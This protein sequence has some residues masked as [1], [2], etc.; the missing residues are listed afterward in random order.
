[1]R[2]RSLRLL[3]RLP[4][5]RTIFTITILV[6][7]LTTFHLLRKD[8]NYKNYLIND[9]KNIQEQNSDI[10]STSE[11]KLDNSNIIIDSS[12]SNKDDNNN[13]LGNLHNS[14]SIVNYS[15][16]NVNSNIQSTQ[17]QENTNN[18]V[19][20]LIQDGNNENKN[21]KK[22]DVSAKPESPFYW[23]KH[24][25]DILA[26]DQTEKSIS[27]LVPDFI[28]GRPKDFELRV[29]K[30]L[31]NWNIATRADQCRILVD[32][33]YRNNKWTNLAGLDKIT[34]DY[35]IDLFG[36]A[37][38]RLRIYNYCFI[39]GGLTYDDI[40]DD[41]FDGTAITRYDFQN[42]M[43][44]FLRQI[45]EN[46]KKQEGDEEN[47]LKA[48]IIWPD[49]YTYDTSIDSFKKNDAPID[50]EPNGNIWESL[51]RHSKGR[52]IVSTMNADHLPMFFKQLKTLDRLGNKLPIQVV[53]TD[54]DLNEEF[55]TKMEE[56]M[57]STN[58][59]VEIMDVTQIMDPD[60][61]KDHISCF[62][63]KWLSVMFNTFEEYI[64]MDVDVVP[65]VDT[66]EFFEIEKYKET[67]I[68]LYKD[69][70]LP[71]LTHDDRCNDF[72]QGIEPSWQEFD[73]IG[74]VAP[75]DQAWLQQNK[76]IPL[77]DLA[78]SE[79]QV[80]QNYF[81]RNQLHHVD[82][83]LVIVDKSRK[84]TGIITSFFLDLNKRI[85]G[86]SYGDKEIFWLGQLAASEPYSI[87]PVEP[88]ITGQIHENIDPEKPD[89]IGV[90]GT[91]IAHANEDEKLTWT[92]GGLRTCK[93][94]DG[95]T[96]DFEKFPDYFQEHYGNVDQLGQF[97][98]SPLEM[99][100]F[101]IPSIHKEQTWEPR[102][103][104]KGYFFC[105]SSL[106]GSNNV[107]LDPS[108]VVKFDDTEK[109]FYKGLADA[110]NNV[111]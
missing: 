6:C 15:D 97:Y 40:F 29:S 51:F 41:Y 82:S 98:S 50:I 38:E 86:C 89:K 72:F 79:A 13:D 88:G 108:V 78:S 45:S 67:G 84:L 74:T 22:T 37:T 65:F 43:F 61:L 104:C 19:N 33:I 93:F 20:S 36:F 39:Q 48:N 32:S 64:F 55:F 71:Q 31:S 23:T 28:S 101:I 110:W 30:I 59:T 80:F 24:L 60:V 75:F 49:I 68:H 100:G 87:D 10:P 14:E 12:E 27:A 2:G 83:G 26:N 96:Y 63:F 44:P 94:D 111:Y 17:Q 47:N 35:D 53:S 85:A 73:I 46:H 9:N 8:F 4:K 42:R 54:T 102:S 62:K 18:N 16:S 105:V 66:N 56:Y 69:R 21:N 106:S 7:L 70:Y 11:I 1:M 103:E 58:Q 91:Q 5:R 52:G 90:C 34:G 107:D 99:Q 92:N 81:V 77:E 57:K 25:I 109:Q 95:N 76:D 3:F